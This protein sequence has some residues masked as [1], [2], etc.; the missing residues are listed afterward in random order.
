M[1]RNLIV[2]RR[3]QIFR[4]APEQV[5]H[6]TSEEKCLIA[7]PQA[8]LLGIK[9]MIEKGN[10][11]S[12]QYIDLLPQSYPPQ[13]DEAG[14]SMSLKDEDTPAV[15]PPENAARPVLTDQPQEP[16]ISQNQGPEAVSPEVEQSDAVPAPDE[17]SSSYGP[18]RRRVTG[19]DGPFSLW[20]PAALKQE[21][22]V[23]IIKEVA[24]TVG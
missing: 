1:G 17:S 24:P 15:N 23:D 21:D 22:F 6:A 9:D 8:E 4:C 7:T 13:G 14:P 2:A 16:M 10:L 18:I 11:S 19:K 3:R 12:K 5:R 20:R